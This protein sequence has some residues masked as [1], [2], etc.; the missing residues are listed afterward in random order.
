MSVSEDGYS[1]L[2]IVCGITFIVLGVISLISNKKYSVMWLALT[3]SIAG[4]ALS[5][6][7][8]KTLPNTPFDT[9][10]VL[11]LLA[12][13][14]SS[15]RLFYLETG[16]ETK[17]T[18]PKKRPKKYTTPKEKPQK[19]HSAKATNKQLTKEQQKI[20]RK[21]QRDLYAAMDDGWSWKISLL[22]NLVMAGRLMT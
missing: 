14:I 12:V 13:L 17:L 11:Y 16:K 2:Q 7:S 1:T 4:C 19:E 6:L 3:L 20:I 22:S 8:I 15:L 18:Q 9:C 21:C 10:W 5:V